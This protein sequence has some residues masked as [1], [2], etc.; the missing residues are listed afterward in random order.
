[1]KGKTMNDQPDAGVQLVE[2]MQEKTKEHVAIPI[3]GTAKRLFIGGMILVREAAQ[4][5]EGDSRWHVQLTDV[6]EDEIGN[7][8]KRALGRQLE[9]DEQ[10]R[11]AAREFME[12]NPDISMERYAENWAATALQMC[13][14]MEYWQKRAREAEERLSRIPYAMVVDG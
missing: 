14:D 8:I 7:S 9:I 3:P 4:G 2:G 13:R 10:A 6:T 5:E 11:V 12:K 1:M